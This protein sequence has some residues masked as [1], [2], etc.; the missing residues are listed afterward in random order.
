MPYDAGVCLHTQ[1]PTTR[2]CVSTPNA[3]RHGRVCPHPTPCPTSAFCSLL[4]ISP[5]VC[6][7]IC[8]RTNNDGLP[9]A[10]YGF[11]VE[12]LCLSA[13]MLIRRTNDGG[14]PAVPGPLLLLQ[15]PHPS[16]PALHR[17]G[18]ACAAA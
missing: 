16:P 11:R 10:P 7:P 6:L 1:C 14:L 12:G 5:Y 4:P 15:S 8:R 9:A 18:M 13:H 3:L 17:G 2:A